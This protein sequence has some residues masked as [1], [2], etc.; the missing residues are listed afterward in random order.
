MF[1]LGI[2]YNNGDDHLRD[3]EF[4]QTLACLHN[5]YF[6]FRNIYFLDTIGNKG[7]QRLAQAL[8]VTK[9]PIQILNLNNINIG[10]KG[11]AILA[12]TIPN[13]SCS[14]EIIDLRWNKIGPKGAT[15]LA[16]VL[17]ANIRNGQ[18]N[19]GSFVLKKLHLNKNKIRDIGVA[20]L[21]AV[22]KNKCTIQVLNLQKIIL[23][24]WVRNV[25][26]KLSKIISHCRG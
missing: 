15:Y 7:A 4:E 2:N 26:P 20:S 8:L 24:I 14:L 11:M 17:H 25:W 18:N 10:N 19:T 3:E 5:N 21:A 23:G 6:E 1:I 9:C 12:K 16:N 13:I 22:L